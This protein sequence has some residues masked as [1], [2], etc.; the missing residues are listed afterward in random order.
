MHVKPIISKFNI[1]SKIWF[2]WTLSQALPSVSSL[3]TIKWTQ[4]PQNWPCIHTKE[5]TKLNKKNSL[6]N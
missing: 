6:I 4:H 1:I 5:Q 2:I 3:K